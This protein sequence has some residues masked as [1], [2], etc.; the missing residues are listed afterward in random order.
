MGRTEARK[1]CVR[2]T[3]YTMFISSDKSYQHNDSKPT[4]VFN[5]VLLLRTSSLI[6]VSSDVACENIVIAVDEYEL[7]EN[8]EGDFDTALS[9]VVEKVD[10]LLRKSNQ[11]EDNKNS[12]NFNDFMSIINSELS[13]IKKFDENFAAEIRTIP[14]EIFNYY[15]KYSETI[16][17]QLENW[18]KVNFD[19]M[20]A[21]ASSL[22]INMNTMIIDARQLLHE[23]QS[24]SEN[25]T[26]SLVYKINKDLFEG[27]KDYADYDKVAE[28]FDKFYKD[29]SKFKTNKIAEEFKEFHGNLKGLFTEI[30]KIKK[31]LTENS[32]KMKGNFVF[33]KWDVKKNIQ[34]RFRKLIRLKLVYDLATKLEYMSNRLKLLEPTFIQKISAFW[35]NITYELE[36]NKEL[37]KTFKENELSIKKCCVNCIIENLSK[38]HD[39]VDNFCKDIICKKWDH[40]EENEMEDKGDSNI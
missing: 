8:I 36:V 26:N 25:E 35:E 39:L 23:Q 18:K 5:R 33:N 4:T 22:M 20:I 10:G 38:I 24:T 28:K 9:T 21:S 12:L 1:S 16:K 17:N 14:S 34:E 7:P 31:D 2:T 13:L 11:Q 15:E 29:L 3:P 40:F 37:V 27:I 32:E 30:D 6:K 19:Q